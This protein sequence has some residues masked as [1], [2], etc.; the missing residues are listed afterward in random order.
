MSM[1]LCGLFMV[2]PG[3]TT[4]TA[5]AAPSWRLT[6]PNTVRPSGQPKELEGARMSFTRYVSD[7]GARRLG[8]TAE[9]EKQ[10]A[11]YTEVAC[12]RAL[13]EGEGVAIVKMRSGTAVYVIP[14][15]E[16]GTI[17]H[18]PSMEAFNAFLRPSIQ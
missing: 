5:S 16:S 14:E 3:L 7:F 10:L 18:F 8:K 4:A 17:A 9:A 2:T 11:Q 12:A 13:V 1:M 15:V 6:L